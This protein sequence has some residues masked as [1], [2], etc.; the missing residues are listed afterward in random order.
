MLASEWAADPKLE[1]LYEKVQLEPSLTGMTL[2]EVKQALK[3]QGG[4]VGKAFMQ[5]KKARA[6]TEDTV[7]Q[8]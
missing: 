4:H 3:E 6:P 1:T 8:V 5:L 2:A 7:Q